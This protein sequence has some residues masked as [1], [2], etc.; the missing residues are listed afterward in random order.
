M[1]YIYE[2]HLGGLYVETEEIDYD[3]LYCEQCGDSD[4][5]LFESND[6]YEIAEFLKDKTD[7]FNTGGYRY[8]H[9]LD[10]MKQCHAILEGE[11][12]GKDEYDENLEVLDS[13]ET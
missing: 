9:T 10:I 1:V 8:E 7:I 6:I 5:L 12:P 11:E 2:N 13:E 3:N 4:S